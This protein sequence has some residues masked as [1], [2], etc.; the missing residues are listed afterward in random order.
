MSD[1]ISKEFLTS[2]QY[3]FSV[4]FLNDELHSNLIREALET[5]KLITYIHIIE[6]CI[7]KYAIFAKQTRI[8]KCNTCISNNNEKSISYIS[9]YAKN[10]TIFFSSYYCCPLNISTEFFSRFK[11]AVFTTDGMH[12]FDHLTSSIS[13][14]KWLNVKEKTSSDFEPVWLGG[15]YFD[16]EPLEAFESSILFI[17]NDKK[18]DRIAFY[19]LTGN[20]LHPIHFFAIY[21]VKSVT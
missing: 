19:G 16:A 5:N 13:Y 3:R 18:W 7:S 15:Y 17:K 12:L 9:M 20:P 21:I 6:C 11:S 2:I 10:L 4:D 8:L 14:L 1:S